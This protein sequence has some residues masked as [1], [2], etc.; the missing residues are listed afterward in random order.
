MALSDVLS[1]TV[2]RLESDSHNYLHSDFYKKMYP[3]SIRD[4]VMNLLDE[5]D[6]IREELDSP[7]SPEWITLPE[8]VIVDG[9]RRSA[10]ELTDEERYKAAKIIRTSDGRALKSRYDGRGE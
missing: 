3:K 2:E 8:E 5:M 10:V 6:S 1:E 7:H 9:I 4:A